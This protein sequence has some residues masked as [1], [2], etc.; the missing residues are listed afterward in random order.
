MFVKEFTLAN[1]S[2][3]ERSKLQE[4]EGTLHGVQR[5]PKLIVP[6][7]E[8]FQIPMQAFQAFQ[9]LVDHMIKGKAYSVIPYNYLLS[10]DE[11]TEYLSA[12]S[13]TFV[14][15][16]LESG[17]LPYVGVGQQ[18]YV[19]FGDLLEYE[20]RVHQERLEFLDEMLEF[21]QETGTLFDSAF[22]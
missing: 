21:S 16:L 4:M 14:P 18:K 1:L 10:V 13:S 11:A 15:S 6:S 9:Q 5:C 2:E 19:Q 7:G 8:T 17:Q 20:K 3:D 22:A 12:A